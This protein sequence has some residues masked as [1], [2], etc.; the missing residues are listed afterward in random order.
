M[1]KCKKNFVSSKFA[2]YETIDLLKQF[3]IGWFLK[4][5]ERYTLNKA[6]EHNLTTIINKCT[7]YIELQVT[8]ATIL[9]DSLKSTYSNH[10][11]N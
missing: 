5:A 2:C 8:I 11:L 3:L 9:D 1:I 6:L 7:R 10:Q 4:I